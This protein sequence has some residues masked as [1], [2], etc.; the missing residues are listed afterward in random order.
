[1]PEFDVERSRGLIKRAMSDFERLQRVGALPE[2]LRRYGGPRAWRLLRRTL[3]RLQRSIERIRLAAWPAESKTRPEWERRRRELEARSLRTES[4]QRELESRQKKLDAEWD[5]V[6]SELENIQEGWLLLQGELPPGQDDPD[7]AAALQERLAKLEL[8]WGQVLQEEAHLARERGL[9]DRLWRW[10]VGVWVPSVDDVLPPG[11]AQQAWTPIRRRIFDLDR[12]WRSS[13]SD[14]KRVLSE[15]EVSRYRERLE[16]AEKRADAL[17]R[18]LLSVKEGRGGPREALEAAI[19]DARRSLLRARADLDAERAE[20]A[21]LQERITELSNLVHHHEHLMTACRRKQLEAEGLARM[22]E[23]RALKAAAREESLLRENASLAKALES[24]PEDEMRSG[25]EKENM[26]ERLKAAIDARRRALRERAVAREAVDQARAQLKARLEAV[27]ETWRER[28]REFGDKL[29][30]AEQRLKSAEA[31]HEVEKAALAASMR[32][33]QIERED[34]RLRL[35]GA[36]TELGARQDAFDSQRR[37]YEEFLRGRQAE[38]QKSQQELTAEREARTRLE[39]EAPRLRQEA[40]DLRKALSKEKEERERL[41]S[42][43]QGQLLEKERVE[44]ALRADSEGKRQAITRFF[45]EVERQRREFEERSREHAQTEEAL[46]KQVED[47]QREL[48]KAS[49]EVEALRAALDSAQ[50]ERAPF[51]APL[52]PEAGPSI[53]PVLEPGWSKVVSLLGGAVAG[54]F[55]HLRGLAAGRLPKGE[56]ALLKL[57]AGELAKA[58]DTLSMLGGYLQEGAPCAKGRVEAVLESA[59]AAWEAAL[60]RRRISLVR[61]ISPVPPAAFEPEALRMALYQVMRN[62]YEAMPRGG[63]LVVQT[64]RDEAGRVCAAFSDTGPGFSSDSLSSLFEAFQSTK[65]GHLG[66]GLAFARRV[67]RRFGGDVSADNGPAG[68]ATVRLTFSASE[69]EAPSLGQPL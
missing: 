56:R 63:S 54:V 8:L 37:A 10:L 20:K 3:E 50:L 66:L 47:L 44:A 53:E 48:A 2:T 61:R 23:G 22:A 18:E 60:R 28:Q 67:L 29:F 55:G 31:G 19:Q 12:R 1:M 64:S 35:E 43:T 21:E 40:E 58:Q 13:L 30:D 57:A 16:E 42:Q 34:L 33:L 49:G 65:S 68:G 26:A 11:A 59:L 51:E 46:K 52:A 14:L 7:F 69:N 17:S 45:A 15:E 62:A 39:E 27:R 25:A 32:E 5:R 4:A 41:G 36:I 38:L 9:V 6:F 24:A